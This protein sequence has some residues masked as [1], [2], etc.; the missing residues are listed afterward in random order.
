MPRPIAPLPVLGRGPV[1]VQDMSF[2]LASIQP[3]VRLGVNRDLS[4]VEGIHAHY[5]SEGVVSNLTSIDGTAA[6]VVSSSRCFVPIGLARLTRL[7]D[8]QRLNVPCSAFEVE[9]ADTV[10]GGDQERVKAM[11]TIESRKTRLEWTT[12]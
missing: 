10:A 1:H 7:A 9:P 12:K 3:S 11:G 4:P 5:V 2:P 6:P 8:V